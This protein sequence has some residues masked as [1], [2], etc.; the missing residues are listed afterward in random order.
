MRVCLNNVKR[1][2]SKVKMFYPMTQGKGTMVTYWL[3]GEKS[4]STN[5]NNV[6]TSRPPS[7][8]NQVPAIAHQHHQHQSQNQSRSTGV[9][10]TGNGAPPS[11]VSPSPLHRT[12]DGAANGTPTHSPLATHLT[13]ESVPNHSDSGPG[14]PLLL[15]GSAGTHPRV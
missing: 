1:K 4:K 14:A 11:L 12:S 5:N 8:V 6:Q 10:L 2:I 7:M 15:S 13:L 9:N 3:Q